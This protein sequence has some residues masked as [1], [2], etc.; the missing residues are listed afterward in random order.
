[1][2]ML[3]LFIAIILQA[4]D[5]TS[6]TQDGK[7]KRTKQS[8]LPTLARAGNAFIKVSKIS[9]KLLARLIS[10]SRRPILKARITE[11][12]LPILPTMPLFSRMTLQIVNITIIKSKL[13]HEF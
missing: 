12:E 1:M 2:M 13:F 3:N 10:R 4:F 11:V 7:I 5:D 9:I 6:K 8:K